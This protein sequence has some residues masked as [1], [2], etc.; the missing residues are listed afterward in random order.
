MLLLALQ[1]ARW[2]LNKAADFILGEHLA[3]E[4]LS[5]GPSLQR[6]FCS[7]SEES[8]HFWPELHI[9]EDLILKKSRLDPPVSS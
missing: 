4:L 2:L 5:S 3:Q 1:H 6:C 7:L 9:R 8:P